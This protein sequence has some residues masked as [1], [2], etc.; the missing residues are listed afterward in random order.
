[1]SRFMEAS[2]ARQG[3]AGQGWEVVLFG[4]ESCTHAV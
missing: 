3:R 1:M 2:K 4:F